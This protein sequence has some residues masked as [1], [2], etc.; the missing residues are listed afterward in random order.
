MGT[1]L[2]TYYCMNTRCYSKKSPNYKNYG[3]RGITIY[4]KWRRNPISF[5]RWAENNGF[6]NGCHIHR[7]DNDKGYFP[8]NCVFISSFEHLRIH[9]N[10]IYPIKNNKA[11]GT[12]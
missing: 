5:V 11:N 8:E 9:W 7:K 3:G 4:E 1:P 6:I 10:G 2:L 12:H